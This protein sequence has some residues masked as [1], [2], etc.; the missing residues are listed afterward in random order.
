MLPGLAL[1][2]PEPEVSVTGELKESVREWIETMREIQKEEDTWERDRELLEDQRE[3]LRRE[4]TDLEE[5]LEIARAEKQGTEKEATEEIET[6]EALIAAR[7]ILGEKVRGLE[8]TALRLLPGLPEP[9]AAEPRNRTLI[10]QIREDAALTGEDADNGLTKR[11]NNVLTLLAKAEEW[12][13][14]V[15]LRDELHTASDGREMNL[16]VIYFG[17]ATAYAVDDAGSFA[18][19]GRPGEEGWEFVERPELVERIL[20]MKQVLT[21]DTD[22][23]FIP[24]P[25]NLK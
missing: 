24:L 9:V 4:I 11:L 19:V 18:L 10:D 25:V 1:A 14:T 22:A 13:Q 5:M 21:G 12:Q 16:K 6:R 7:E 17:L 23:K 3:A 2:A 8:D 15:H 20:E